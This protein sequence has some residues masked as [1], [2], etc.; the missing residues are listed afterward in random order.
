MSIKSLSNGEVKACAKL[1]IYHKYISVI[2]K[3]HVV[4][5]NSF[6]GLKGTQAWDILGAIIGEGRIVPRSLRLRGTKDFQ[7][8]K[9]VKIMHDPFIFAN[10]SF[11]KIWSMNSDG[12]NLCQNVKLDLS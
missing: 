8:V 4:Y 2:F 12:D 11:S 1:F 3:K 10:N 6:L 9:L 5:K 7:Q